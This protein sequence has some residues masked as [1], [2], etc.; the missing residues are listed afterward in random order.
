MTDKSEALAVVE[1]D[2]PQVKNTAIEIRNEAPPAVQVRNAFD[3]A[4]S[5]FKAGLKRQGENRTAL[6][7]WIKG[8]M[9]EGVDYG[10]IHVVKRDK[11]PKGKYCDNPQH[12][13]KDSL[14]KPGAEKI[15]GM[16]GFRA[17]W[18]TLVKYEQAAIEGK[19]ISQVALRCQ[20]VD[21][22][23]NIISE[24]WGARTLQQDYG[25]LNK[26][27]K[28]AKKSGLIDAVLNAGG[29][30]EVFTQ[31]VEDLPPDSFGDDPPF[32]PYNQE[33]VRFDGTE[34]IDPKTAFPFGK[35]KGQ[36]WADVPLDYLEWCLDKMTNLEPDTRKLIE[37]A[38]AD[39]FVAPEVTQRSF[40]AKIEERFEEVTEEQLKAERLARA[41]SRPLQYYAD[42]IAS[43]AGQLELENVKQ[44]IAGS[45]HEKPLKAFLA[46][47]LNNFLN[48]KPAGE[49][50]VD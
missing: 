49:E 2:G 21:K 41:E 19:Q 18:P 17:I 46:E 15:V 29:L 23:G 44:D 9:H 7:I 34:R 30:S 43:A 26:A 13:S 1:S 38:A 31:D 27:V 32:D 12:F 50:N 36:P 10:K 40:D 28:M 39:K 33:Q 5:Q 35:H 8:E 6:M 47:R 48:W 37:Q 11:C 14:F 20:L 4:P 22:S 25:D 3:L 16:M 42:L 45:I 24:G